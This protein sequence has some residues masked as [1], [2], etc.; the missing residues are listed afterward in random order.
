MSDYCDLCGLPECP[1]LGFETGRIIR[2]TWCDGPPMRIIVATTPSDN[3]RSIC[4]TCIRDIK[5]LAFSDF[6]KVEE[7]MPF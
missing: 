6:A 4:E 5:R 7:E 3:D 1:E 2:I